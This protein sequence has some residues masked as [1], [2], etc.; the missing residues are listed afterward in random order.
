V[1]ASFAAALA[2]AVAFGIASLLQ[3]SGARRAPDSRAV[4]L[5]LLGSLL[6]QPAF[7]AGTGLDAAG[8][9]L[10]FLALRHLPLFA[11]EAA[12]SSAVAVTA[13]G[14]VLRGAR[15]TRM[16]RRAVAAVVV[17]L[18]VIAA[19]ARPEGPPALSGL[20]RLALLAGAPALA[21]AGAAAGRRLRG[22]VA[23]P[24]LGALA[25][26]AFALFSVASRL[27]PA[28]GVG[29]D[30][31]TVVVVAYAGLGVL[32]YGAALQRG[33]VT[34]VAACTAAVE[35]LVPAAAGLVLGD[36]AR[37]GLGAV[38]ALGF[39][40]TALATLTLVRSSG[41]AGECPE[42]CPETDT[43]DIALSSPLRPPPLTVV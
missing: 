16:D 13:A 35:T 6:A 37:P 38:A 2:A 32:L 22:S 29:R 40:V 10:T 5:R 26:L 25:G 15:L 18:G 39:A 23:A 3:E 19:A 4:G 36:G 43:S 1:V 24:A 20:A 12:V 9:V 8:F 34:A 33:A 30:P 31:L 11:V 21:A 7:L 27:L 42:A 17:G 14:S 41:T 28:G